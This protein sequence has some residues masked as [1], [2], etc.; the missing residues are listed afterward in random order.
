MTFEAHTPAPALNSTTPGTQASPG[1]RP[2]ALRRP[3]PTLGPLLRLLRALIS[4]PPPTVAVALQGRTWGRRLL[5]WRFHRPG[6]RPELVVVLQPL[7][8]H[9]LHVVGLGP[10]RLPSSSAGSP[11]YAARLRHAS[12]RRATSDPGPASAPASGVVY[13][14]IMVLVHCRLGPYRPRLRLQHHGFGPTAFRRVIYSGASYHTTPTRACS[15]AHTHL[16]PH[17]LP[18]S[19]LETVPLFRSP[20]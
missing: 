4:I 14:D 1:G 11:D 9:H 7:D 10:Q 8:Q 19:S 12:I 6:R 17:T 3:G 2:A 15:L 5:S 18:R 20:L 16:L 13:H